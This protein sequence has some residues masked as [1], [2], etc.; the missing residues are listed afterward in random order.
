MEKYKAKK[1]DGKTKQEH[2]LVMEKHLER[3]LTKKEIVHHIDGNK[4][5][6]NID[7]LMLFPTKKAH[8][9]FHYLQGDLKLKAGSNKKELINGKLKCRYCEELKDLGEFGVNKESYLGVVQTCRECQ[10][11]NRKQDSP[12]FV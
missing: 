3:K 9:K 1:I 6:N 10:R 4:S 5:N 11:I 8:T 2:R 7:N 12:K